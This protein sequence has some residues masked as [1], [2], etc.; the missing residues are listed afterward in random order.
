MR[1]SHFDRQIE[2]IRLIPPSLHFSRV[3]LLPYSGIL[4]IRLR[5]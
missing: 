5:G 1:V 4:L 2:M 3:D